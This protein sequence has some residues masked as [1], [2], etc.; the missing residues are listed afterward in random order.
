MEFKARLAMEMNTMTK[1]SKMCKNKSLSNNTKLR[2][3]KALV[4]PVISYGCETWTLNKAKERRIQAFEN[5]CMRK[6]LRVPWTH[7]L[8]ST[9]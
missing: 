1:A 4:W 2:L 7:K 8:T 3:V 6:I 9:T 5:K